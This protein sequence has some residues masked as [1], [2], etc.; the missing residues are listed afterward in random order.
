VRRDGFRD[1]GSGGSAG[2]SCVGVKR[3]GWNFGVG[4]RIRPNFFGS[5]DLGQP[6]RGFL[7]WRFWG[8]KIVR[9]D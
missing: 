3:G 7:R 8:C 2:D 1:F 5:A 9:W 6:G 4:F